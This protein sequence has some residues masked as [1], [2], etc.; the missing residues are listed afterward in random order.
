MPNHQSK[1]YKPTNGVRTDFKHLM[2]IFL[3]SATVRFEQ[4]SEVWRALNMSYLCAG[5]NSDREAREVKYS[6]TTFFFLWDIISTFFVC[7]IQ[8]Y[9]C[10]SSL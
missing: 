7:Y 2:N 5:R 9:L 3:S 10:F 6:D 4:F 1:A 8:H